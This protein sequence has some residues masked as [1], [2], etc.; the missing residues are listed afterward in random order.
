[1][2]KKK[3]FLTKSFNKCKIDYCVAIYIMKIFFQRVQKGKRNKHL[4]S[5]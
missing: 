4:L 1:M 2:G 5:A 3:R